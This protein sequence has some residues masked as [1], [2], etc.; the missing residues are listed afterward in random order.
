VSL[1]GPCV[2]AERRKGRGFHHDSRK[3]HPEIPCPLLS[4][5]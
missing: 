5:H 3:N 4:L 2:D 1:T